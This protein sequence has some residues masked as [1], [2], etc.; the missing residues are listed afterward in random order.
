MLG[1]ELFANL[2]VIGFEFDV[3]SGACRRGSGRGARGNGNLSSDV[4]LEL[5]VDGFR[6]AGMPE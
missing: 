1:R 3:R 5:V 2:G 6:K 4:D